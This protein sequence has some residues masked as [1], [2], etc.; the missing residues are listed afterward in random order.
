MVDFLIGWMIG[1]FLHLLIHLLMH[2]FVG[3]YFPRWQVGT[4]IANGVKQNGEWKDPTPEVRHPML[5]S[6]SP[7]LAS[8]TLALPC[9]NLHACPT[10]WSRYYSHSP[11][12]L[13]PLTNSSHSHHHCPAHT[14]FV[15]TL[16]LPTTT[17]LPSPSLAV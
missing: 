17:L 10:I 7:H 15:L 14:P 2:W 5:P 1:G 6:S 16:S 12:L 8:A 9:H 13:T 4:Y 3:R 11:L